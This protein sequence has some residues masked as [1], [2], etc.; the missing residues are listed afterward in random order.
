M[1]RLPGELCLKIFHLLDHRSLAA[2]PQVCRK[3]RVLASD[4]ALWS[5]LFKERWGAD[6]AA[7][8]AP[9]DPKSWKDVYIVQ[10]RCDRFGL[11]L[12]I[13]TEAPLQDRPSIYRC[14]HAL[15][16]KMNETAHCIIRCSIIIQLMANHTPEY[17]GEG[18]FLAEQS[19]HQRN[20]VDAITE[21]SEYCSGKVL[22]L[23]QKRVNVTCKATKQ[24]RLYPSDCC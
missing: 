7:F 6:S 21:N 5:N 10:H 12:R 22:M 4:D 9:T 17:V 19:K 18:F 13:I 24:G 16:P 14:E 15:W 2:A 3:W 11:G 1:E 8:Y 20:Q 23:L